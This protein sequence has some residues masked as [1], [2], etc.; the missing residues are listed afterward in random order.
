MR[1]KS[2]LVVSAVALGAV[3]ACIPSIGYGQASP[4]DARRID[5]TLTA[6]AEAMDDAN[7]QERVIRLRDKTL[8]EYGFWDD[9]KAGYT[10]ARAAARRLGPLLGA[11]LKADDPLRTLKVV[12]VAMALSMMPQV[13]IQPALE[14][15]VAHGNPAVRLFGWM[16]YRRTRDRL[17]SQGEAFAGKMFA[18]LDKSAD[19]ERSPLVL[20]AMF[21]MLRMD[22]RPAGLPEDVWKAARRRSLGILK[23]NWRRWCVKVASCQ[24]EMAAASL[25]LVDA[26]RAHAGAAAENKDEKKQKAA[27]K[28]LVQMAYDVAWFASLA[29]QKTYR[30]PGMG[31][32]AVGDNGA[33]LRACERALNAMSGLEHKSIVIALTKGDDDGRAERVRLAVVF[34]WLEALTKNYGVTE[35]KYKEP[36]TK[37]ATAAAAQ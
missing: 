4:L 7:D 16:G 33:L 3:V 13:T 17:M 1:L 32:R 21:R 35:P 18:A 29:Y 14:T 25:R 34:Y 36:T 6:I 26:V 2:I 23:R 30:K 5:E 20:G 22:A 12:N 31:M 24:P 19:T 27:K 10:F 15:M 37:P 8:E 11:G 9:R 28:L